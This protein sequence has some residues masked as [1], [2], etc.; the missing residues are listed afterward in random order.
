MP[1]FRQMIIGAAAFL[2]VCWLLYG[3]YVLIDRAREKK[4]PKKSDRLQKADK[5]FTTYMEKMQK[6]EKK[7]YDKKDLSQ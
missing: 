5:S 4:R 6:Y 3:I 7:T 2:A 1:S